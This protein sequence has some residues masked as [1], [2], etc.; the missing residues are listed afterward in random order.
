MLGLEAWWNRHLGLEKKLM[1]LSDTVAELETNFAAINDK[2]SAAVAEM[3]KLAGDVA[4]LQAQ[5][6]SAGV[7]PALLAR[8]QTVADN[9]GTLAQTLGSGTPTV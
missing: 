2:V 5:L 4:A 7:D 1:A 3:Q 6:A 9:L 8:A